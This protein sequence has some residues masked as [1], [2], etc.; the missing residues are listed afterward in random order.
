MEPNINR[1]PLTLA[2]RESYLRNYDR[3]LR[4]TRYSQNQQAEKYGAA[5]AAFSKKIR[6]SL[7]P[8][9]RTNTSRK[10][11]IRNNRYQKH[12]RL[13]PSYT[14]GR[15]LNMYINN[16]RQ[17][18]RNHGGPANIEA[19]LR[20]ERLKHVKSKI[21]RVPI[22]LEG[23]TLIRELA[24]G[25][26]KNLAKY[27]KDK[28]ELLRELNGTAKLNVK[29][30]NTSKRP[31]ND[32]VSPYK[33]TLFT[34]GMYSIVI[35]RTS[36]TSDAGSIIFTYGSQDDY[37]NALLILEQL[38]EIPK[39]EIDFSNSKKSYTYMLCFGHKILYENFENV[40]DSDPSDE[41][42]AKDT[43]KN[44]Y[45][46]DMLRQLL[47]DITHI[48][49]QKKDRNLDINITGNVRSIINTSFKGVMFKDTAHNISYNMFQNGRITAIVKD[50]ALK[51]QIYPILKKYIDIIEN[52]GVQIISKTKS[53]CESLTDYTLTQKK[54]IAKQQLRNVRNYGNKNSFDPN[55]DRVANNKFILPVL[56][57]QGFIQVNAK[58]GTID[59]SKVIQRYLKYA[60]NV[61]IENAAVRARYGLNRIKGLNAERI[62]KVKNK[63]KG[64]ATANN[65]ARPVAKSGQKAK[66]VGE[67]KVPTNLGSPKWVY[68]NGSRY[69]GPKVVKGK[70]SLNKDGKPVIA[71]YK[72]FNPAG[73][74]AGQIK[75][76]LNAITREFGLLKNYYKNWGGKVPK[77]I[78][79]KLVPKSLR[80]QFGV[81]ISPNRAA[82]AAAPARSG[83]NS[84]S[85]SNSNS[86]NSNFVRQIEENMLEHQRREESAKRRS[87]EQKKMAAA[88]K[89][90]ANRAAA[91]AE[92]R[93]QE[94]SAERRHR[95]NQ[96]RLR[97]QARGA[98]GLR[99]AMMR[100]FPKP[101]SP[102]PMSKY[103]KAANNLEAEIRR[104]PPNNVLKR[105]APNINTAGTMKRKISE[106]NIARMKRK[107]TPSPPKPPPPKP[108]RNNNNNNSPVKQ[109]TGRKQSASS[110]KRRTV[111]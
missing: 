31:S 44:A 79:E 75:S 39:S 74:T 106:S 62:K 78:L 59:P 91:S 4:T 109:R 20:A 45:G 108:N 90:A 41:G 89:A 103:K 110:I 111:S 15:L 22:S 38:L 8:V 23:P 95:E 56:S 72:L 82:P 46:K 93:R 61:N 84:A 28:G 86:N 5:G 63:G 13:S 33:V 12:A 50:S 58:Q 36:I 67:N 14:H 53:I 80:N 66:T 18:Y 47:K 49:R 76:A 9:K 30:Y 87:A 37:N 54:S 57:G 98:Q 100:P 85:N 97:E 71:S 94:A 32:V 83:S 26:I 77:K 40:I 17:Y 43:L 35:E 73:K 70:L 16:L 3:W 1:Y 6:A 52:G 88:N 2:G 19:H 92:R 7:E 105:M 65:G 42:N 60:P 69:Y 101:K 48:A 107:R 104:Q 68:E 11:N 21:Q 64:P 81:R 27:L 51:D 55:T 10:P 24:T 96:R 25:K 29:T 99:E 102:S 34:K